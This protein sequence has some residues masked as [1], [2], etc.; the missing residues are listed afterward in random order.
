MERLWPRLVLWAA[1]LL[2]AAWVLGRFSTLV[3]MAII[4]LIVTFPIYPAVDW[5]E[6]RLRFSRGGAAACMLLCL[7]IILVLGLAIV[8]PW[9]SSQAQIL[10]ELAPRGIAVVRDFLTEWQARV[11]EPTFPQFLRTAWERAGEAAVSA[12]NATVTRVVNL[13]VGLIGQLYLVLLLP[14]VIYFVLLDYRQI[15]ASVLALVP[16]PT[17]GRLTDLLAELTV[18]LRWGLWAQVVVSSIVGVLT[19]LGLWIVGVPGPLA[20]GVFAGVAEAIPYIGGFAT[21]GVVLLAAA[22]E[23]GMVWAW[24]LAIV[25]VVK[26]LSNVLVPLVL[27]RMTH[28]HPLAIIVALL[29]LGQLFGLVGMFFAVPAVVIVREILA[30]WQPLQV[31]I[32]GGAAK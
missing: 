7:I 27:G 19:A 16:E 32:T 21:Y 14:F 6:T 20:I 30:W 25:T 23:G 9:I 5:L 18:T 10:I 26:V 2:A 15:R 24:G 1:G 22:P 12:A 3:T 11:A 31:G 17:R 8:I 29:A 13:A 4:V 28:T